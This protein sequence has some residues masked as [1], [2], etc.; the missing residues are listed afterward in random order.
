M[1]ALILEGLDSILDGNLFVLTSSKYAEK[2]R[3]I[4][5]RTSQRLNAE[6]FRFNSL[7]GKSKDY[8]RLSVFRFKLAAQRNVS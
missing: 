2:Q 5:Y 4:G 7:N 6:F 8:E 3:H 1:V